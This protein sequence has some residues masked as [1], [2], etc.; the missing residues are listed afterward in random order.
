[1]S[2]ASGAARLTG[3]SSLSAPAS[4]L[5]SVP[6]MRAKTTALCQVNLIT[7]GLLLQPTR[8]V[9]LRARSCRISPARLRNWHGCVP[10][11]ASA[12]LHAS[13]MQKKDLC[14]CVCVHLSLS[15]SLLVCV[16]TFLRVCACVQCCK[17]EWAFFELRVGG[18]ERGG[19][20]TS[21]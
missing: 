7:G 5:F 16:S 17:K 15:L 1:M 11:H 14:V 9:R 20:D 3:A 4:R 19:A 6:E 10:L 2:R 12:L 13:S 8:S 18:G 21:H